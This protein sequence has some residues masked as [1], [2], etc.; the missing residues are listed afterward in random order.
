MF[1]NGVLGSVAPGADGV[2]GLVCSASPV[3]GGLQL[4]QPYLLRKIGDLTDLGVTDLPEDANAFLRRH[5]IE[6]Y[7]EAGEGSELWLMCFPRTDK[8]SDLVDPSKNKA[9][10]LIKAAAGRIRVLAVALDPAAGY[11]PTIAGGVDGDLFPAMQKA[12][13]LAEQATEKNFAPLLVL[14]EARHFNGKPADLRNLAEFEYNRVGVLLGDTTADSLGAAVGL[15]LGRIARI[16]V[17]RHIGRVRDGAV[18]SIRTFV[19]NK[20]TE[21][22]DAETVNDRGYVTFRTFVGKAGYFFADDG[23]ATKIADD[24]RSIARRRTVDKAYRIAY[25]TLIEFLLDEIPITDAGRLVPAMTKAWEMEVE[26]AVVNRMTAEGNLGTDPDDPADKGVK[27]RIDTEQ[28]VAVDGKIEIA[29]KVKPY[30]YAKYIDVKLG[31]LV[32]KQ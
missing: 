31:F 17:Q 32:E 9:S 27:C 18:K 6:F 11:S 5:V 25:E 3:T 8:Q 23:L 16:P 28:N 15:L 26:T 7:A 4:S 2:A 20:R 29:L 22:A 12:Q 14:L 13:A 24:Y 1:E 30:G 10:E 21:S 19:G